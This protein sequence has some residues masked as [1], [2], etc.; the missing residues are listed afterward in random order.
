MRSAARQA[1]HMFFASGG[2]G[3]QWLFATHPPLEV[4]IRR[5]DPAVAEGRAASPAREALVRT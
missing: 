2:G 4:R 1:S 3:W 5:L